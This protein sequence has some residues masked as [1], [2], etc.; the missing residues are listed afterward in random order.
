MLSADDEYDDWSA[1]YAEASVALDERDEKIDAVYEELEHDLRLLGA[2]AIEDKLQD[3]VPETIADLKEAGI[4]IWV[5][6]G[7]KLETAIGESTDYMRSDLVSLTH[8][9]RF[10]AIG[11]STNLI[12][13]D[14]NIVII[15]GGDENSR[16]VYTQMTAAVEEF[17]PESGILQEE[18]ILENL[19]DPNAGE[20]YSLRRV[21][22]GHTSIVGQ[23]NGSRPGGYVLVIDGGALNHVRALIP[24]IR[25]NEDDLTPIPTG[26]RRRRAQAAAAP[27]R[28]AV[29]QRHLLSCVPSAKGSYRQARQ[30]RSWCDDARYR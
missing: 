8:L 5:A 6:T 17:F 29:R 26:A 10:T 13:R 25:A 21:D 11:H 2:T 16:P 20:P 12:G 1:K 15:R 19:Q 22:T 3:G 24:S 23:G 14:D 30:G 28:G 4:K 7:D 9:P 18:G 27:P